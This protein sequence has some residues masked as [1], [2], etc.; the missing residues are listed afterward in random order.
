MKNI[1]GF[2]TLAVVCFTCLNH[3]Q[4]SDHML[5]T[6]DIRIRDPYIFADVKNNTYYMYAQSS[7]PSGSQG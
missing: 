1:F 5:K 7:N 3:A 4:A 2:F 6:E